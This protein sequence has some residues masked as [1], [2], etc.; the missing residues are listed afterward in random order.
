MTAILPR[1]SERLPGRA[2]ATLP[3]PATTNLAVEATP[4]V[5]WAFY[6]FV[7]SI[8]F[9]MPQGRTIPLE[10]PTITGALFLLAT[11]LDRRAC[12]GRIPAPWLCFLGWLWVFALAALVNAREHAGLVLHYFLNMLQ[13]LLVC[14]AGLNL[15]RYP[16]VLRAVLVTL[17]VAC[18]VRAAMQFVGIALTARHV[19]TGGERETVL[20]QNAN[21]SALILASG[22]LATLGLRHAPGRGILRQPLVFWPVL[23][24]LG[25]AVVHT[26]S[27]GGL[28]A[29]TAGLL[30]SLFRGRTLWQRFRSALAVL[31]AMGFL[32]WASFN[33]QVMRNRFEEAAE[34]GRFAGRERIYPAL[35][36]MLV[37]RPIL[38]WGPIG[39]QFELARRIGE[40]EKPRRDAHNLLLELLTATGLVGFVPFA[41]GLALALRAAWRA[42][43]GPYG[44]LP[45]ALLATMALGTMSGTW[46]AA[47]IF[48]LT[49]ACTLA[50]GSRSTE[51]RQP[52]A[53]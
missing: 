29:L 26:G 45:L 23:L 48:W 46:I 8:P 20:G 14:W 9:E 49:L 51:G 25:A 10:I 22:L 34:K 36:G 32:V 28:L 27:R 24:L 31:F 5:R 12:Y 11:L 2:H 30:V 13:L 7:F 1:P 38:G 35:L 47:K 37:E 52:C 16:G 17:V 6:L 19:W 4:L 44:I 42:R 21:L 15:M 41:A 50:A 3:P 18:I 43:R 40:R 53:A 39:N 33:T